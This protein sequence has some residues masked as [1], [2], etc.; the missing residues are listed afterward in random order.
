MNPDS[1]NGSPLR[2]KVRGLVRDELLQAAEAVFAE[3]GLKTAKVED[4]ASRAGVSVGTV[5]NYF[6]D[7]GALVEAVM[8]LRR[9]GLFRELHRL[10]LETSGQPFLQRLEITVERVLEYFAGQRPY[11]VM[12]LEAEGIPQIFQTMVK[13]SLAAGSY[14]PGCGGPFS[15]L[16]EQLS[17]L[18]GEG[19]RAGVLR[20]EDPG[21]H[22]A[23]LMGIS[24]GIAFADLLDPNAPDVRQ[25][26]PMVLRFFLHG[27]SPEGP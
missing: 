13:S 4:I 17:R 20:D 21:T 1:K 2:K 22:A 8:E 23:F 25:R 9:E 6:A 3:K 26:K 11:Y 24:K 10:E 7:R 18:M 15:P 14:P 19:I 5:Y 12:M 27:A 16:F